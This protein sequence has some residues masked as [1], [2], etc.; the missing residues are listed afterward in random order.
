MWSLR[1]QA[2]KLKDLEALQNKESRILLLPPI[3]GG[4]FIFHC[5]IWKNV[6]KEATEKAWRVLDSKLFHTGVFRR[7]LP[8][9]I[10]SSTQGAV[11]KRKLELGCFFIEWVNDSTLISYTDI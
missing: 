8:P 5:L 1:V 6:S 7:L 9:E 10:H 2:R 3:T 11:A 4:S